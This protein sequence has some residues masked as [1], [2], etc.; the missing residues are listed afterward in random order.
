M[1][2][3]DGLYGGQF[4]T[5]MYAEAFFEDDVVKI[6]KAGL[7]CIPAES[8]YAECILDVLK[9]H[10]QYPGDWQ[11]TW[12]LIEEKYQDNPAYRRFSCDKGEFNIDAKINGAYIIMGLLYGDGDPDKTIVISTR[13]G[14]DSDCNPSNA[15]GVL[16]TTI[17]YSNLP[18]RFIS[19]I[20]P[21]GKFSH[22]PYNFPTLIEVCNRLVQQAV[23]RTGG[24]I[25]KD[26][27]GE[28]I[29]VIPVEK[30]KPSGLEN[31]WEPG[32]AAECRFTKGEMAMITEGLGMDISE[33][34]EKFA[35]GWEVAKCG[36][37]MD[38]GI[39]ASWS[40]RENVLVTHPL[41][42]DTGCVLSK[43]VEL[44]RGKKSVLKL[45]VGHHPS[46]D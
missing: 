41:D 24:R 39:R 46:G 10:K 11:K 30:V 45:V 22:T 36:E 2:Y 44:P 7:E 34:I 43:E 17:G 9:W 20:N 32:P 28:E 40:G 8:Q 15:A 29:F 35:P 42:E 18:E 13:C 26:A 1:N 14:Q 33:A 6:V 21:E 5:G 27:D 16:F 3:G 12:E 4:V 38:P 23:F 25:E 37:E 31:C 19:A